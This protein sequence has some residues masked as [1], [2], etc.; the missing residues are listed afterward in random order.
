MK[1]ISRSALS[2]LL[3]LCFI[4]TALPALAAGETQSK[5][6][7][8]YRALLVGVL[9][10]DGQEELNGTALDVNRMAKFLSMQSNP[11][12]VNKCIDQTK[13]AVLEAISAKFAGATND[14]VSLFYFS[15]H[16]GI[17]SGQ[18]CIMM[19]D[20]VITMTELKDALD[21]VPG[22]KIIL[23]DACESGS[24]IGKSLMAPGKSQDFPSLV[25]EHFSA[26]QNAK[27]LAAQKYRVITSAH[28]SEDS[29]EINLHYFYGNFIIGGEDFNGS[30][31]DFTA[32]LLLGAAPVT[33]SQTNNVRLQPLAD[34]NSDRKIQME[35]LAAYLE[36]GVLYSSAQSYD[37]APGQPLFE[38]PSSASY[39]VNNIYNP[40]ELANLKAGK[41]MT[42]HSPVQ[43]ESYAGFYLTPKDDPDLDLDIVATLYEGYF[44][45]PS[46]KTVTFNGTG[47][48]GKPLKAGGY[49][50]VCVIVTENYEY[51]YTFGYARVLSDTYTVTFDKNA[52]DAKGSMA[53]Q[54]HATGAS[55]KLSGNTFTRKGYAFSGWATNKTGKVTYKDTA[56]VKNLT[57]ENNITLY[58]VWT[59]VAAPAKAVTNL[60]LKSAKTKQLTVSYK[61]VTG[62]DGYRIQYSTTSK[63]TGS[64]TKTA[65][66]TGASKTLTGLKASTRYYIRVTAYK[67]DSAK[68]KIYSTKNV[69]KNLVIK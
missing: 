34:F 56:S 40:G 12:T 37:G 30:G 62:A 9:D 68:N 45:E 21:Q 61:K 16:G 50:L 47:D 33:I 44:M 53:K 64:S 35:E 26:S 28:S 58:A 20:T 43:G 39:P 5:A 65:Y 52:S 59:K 32:A 10:A 57:T 2:F 36:T 23:I 13:A 19:K 3:C 41:Q 25:I 48:D 31:G 55:K 42:F 1:K 51:I 7:V 22:T 6:A 4:M 69:T 49:R 11:Y 60:T 17:L 54:T 24:F 66:V 38:L 46:S 29:Y 27:S 14:D 67:L 15:G 18:P 63:F 8:T